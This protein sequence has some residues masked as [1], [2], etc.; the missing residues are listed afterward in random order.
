MPVRLYEIASLRNFARLSLTEAIPDGTSILN[1]VA[2]P[3]GLGFEDP[4][5]VVGVE[6]HGLDGCATDP[7]FPRGPPRKR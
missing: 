2:S 3:D 5:I 1:V 7:Q 6:P 4:R